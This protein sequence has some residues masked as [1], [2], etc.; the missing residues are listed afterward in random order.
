MPHEVRLLTE[1][2][3]RTALPLDARALDVVEGAFAALA[4]GDVVMPPVMSMDLP[5]INA[6]VDVKTAFVPGLDGFAIKV[7]PGFFDNPGLGLASLNGLMVLLSART[8]LVRAVFLDNGY[9][10]DLRTAA[11]GSL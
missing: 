6:E 2:D 3:L 11:A 4:R 1:A 5:A 8:G 9:L 10:T 7:S